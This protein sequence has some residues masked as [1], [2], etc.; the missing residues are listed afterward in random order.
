[1]RIR[2]AH[3]L[4]PTAFFELAGEALLSGSLTGGPLVGRFE[5]AL[6]ARL[7]GCEVVA[8]S[9]GTMAALLSFM[10][11]REQGV[12]RVVLPSFSFP[13]VAAAARLAGLDLLLVDIEPHGLG[14]D[15][16][17]AGKARLDPSC[18]LL[19]LDAFG[20][21]EDDQGI[22][23]LVQKTGCTWMEDAACAFGSRA[24]GHACGT[25]SHLAILSF[26]PR[27]TLTCGE[28]GAVVTRDP[29]LAV[30]LRSLRNLGL[31][32]SGDQRRFARTGTNGRMSEL[33][34]AV[35]LSQ[36]ALFDALL[37]K[38]RRLGREYVAR[39]AAIP[40]LVV[41][42]G[43]A[44]KGANFQSVAVR[45]PKRVRRTQVIQRL[46]RAGIE[47]TVAGFA[48]HAQ[49]AFGGVRTEGSL[50]HSTAWHQHGLA[51]PLNERMELQQIEEVTT[52]LADAFKPGA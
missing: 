14:I 34:A 32:G 51:L 49:P 13:S 29:K 40:D 18:V 45:L 4:V 44:H 12:R 41:P 6:S 38:R 1:M 5:Q 7:E 17:A 21:P 48:I 42:A 11:L 2:L 3:P 16:A 31:E 9:S 43:F 37:E 25:A 30:A 8:V 24:R 39:L 19:S 27:K 10:A 50:P 33:H 35:G 26:H 23:R 22:A 36:L 28:G 15:L 52:K 46:A 20:I 47:S